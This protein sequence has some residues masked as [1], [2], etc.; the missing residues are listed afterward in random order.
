MGPAQRVRFS[1]ASY[2][3][4]AVAC[5]AVTAVAVLVGALWLN[6]REAAPAGDPSDVVRVGVVQ[7]QTVP[8]YLGSSRTEL[9]ALADPSAPA[10]GDTWALVSL[11]EYVPAGRLAD[12]F[13]GTAVA[14]VYARVPVPEQHTQVVRIPVY[15]LPAD[16]LT[17]DRKSVV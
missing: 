15:R 1:G 13:D 10:S 4:V 8:G 9:R 11:S 3:R 17:G 2:A 16:V 7:G 14:Q 6:R 5:A 12:L